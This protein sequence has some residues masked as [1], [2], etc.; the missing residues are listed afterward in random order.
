MY[1]IVLNPIVDNAILHDPKRNIFLTA[2]RLVMEDNCAGSLEFDIP[3]DHPQYDAIVRLKCVIAVLRD[4]EEIWWGRPIEEHTSFYKVKHIYCEGLLSALHDTVQPPNEFHDKTPREMLNALFQEHEKQIKPSFPWRPYFQTNI[5]T[6]DANLYRYTNYET[7]LEVINEKLIERLGGHIRIS[8]VANTTGTFKFDYLQDY[9][10]TAQQTIRFG[11]NLL[12]YAKNLD[13]SDFAT[14][15]IPLGARIDGETVLGALDKYLDV[16]DVNGGSIF[17]QDDALVRKYGKI[18]KVVHFDDITVAANLLTKAKKYLTEMQYENIQLEIQAVDFHLAD[19]DVEAID[20]LDEIR[21]VS[22]PHNLD[23]YFPVT[24]ME[25]PLDDPANMMLTLGTAVKTSLTDQSNESTSDLTQRITEIPAPSSILLQAK[26]QATELIKSGALGGHVV[27]LENELYI[28]DNEDITAAKRM[29]RWNLG[30]LAYSSDGGKT[31]GNAAITMDG[32][33][34]ANFITAGTM[35]ADRIKGGTLTLGGSGNA[36]GQIKVL[37]G[38]G[39]L[40]GSWGNN[41]LTATGDLTLK[42]GTQ[43]SGLGEADYL[44]YYQA[45][46]TVSWKIKNGFYA[47]NMSGNTIVSSFAFFPLSGGITEQVYGTT[48]WQKMIVFASNGIKTGTFYRLRAV[49]SGFTLVSGSYG[50]A[51][52]TGMVDASIVSG[53][54]NIAAGAAK[55]KANSDGIFI[56]SGNGSVTITDTSAEISSGNGKYLN[57]G[58]KVI[59]GSRQSAISGKSGTNEFTIGAGGTADAIIEF[60]A[61]TNITLR[62]YVAYVSHNGNRLAYDSSSS[63][64]YKH[65]IKPLSGNRNPHKL[66]TLPVR[67]FEWNEDHNLQYADMKGQVIPGIIAEDV[68]KVYP[69]AVIHD[70]KGQVESWDERRLIPGML[71]LIQEQHK[72]IKAL[73]RRFKS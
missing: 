18:T 1:T 41:G 48:E 60:K 28:T 21:V 37:D 32:R 53:S 2:P 43:I 35:Y 24:R 67:E 47:R 69:S 63:I 25:I 17:V 56:E 59:M 39:T 31:Y 4:G 20:L 26:A 45:A 6:V 15:I 8:R 71:A 46:G 9:M 70:E 54:I 30:G 34:T 3:P 64:R 22:E 72:R 11:Q 65:N 19:S 16:A 14:V 55:F 61:G 13:A 40:I 7:T 58:T 50:S 12:D 23:M 49:K 10:T 42:K 27:V 36:N 66:Y 73:E 44:D 51:S 68:E 62:A 29:W 57:A 33:I 5:V 52:T 38:A